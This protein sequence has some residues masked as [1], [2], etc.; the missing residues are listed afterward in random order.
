MT[1]HIVNDSRQR[2]SL[3]MGIGG[4]G[5]GGAAQPI[6]LEPVTDQEI[7]SAGVFHLLARNAGNSHDVGRRRQCLQP[8]DARRQFRRHAGLRITLGSR[9]RIA[10]LVGR[11]DV[12][13]HRR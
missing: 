3:P 6:Q 9:R 4:H 11:Q 5:P 1:P 7:S 12:I 8:P 13:Q 10:P 2:Q